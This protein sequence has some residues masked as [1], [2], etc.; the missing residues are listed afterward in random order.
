MKRLG[1]VLLVLMG[2][3]GR[4]AVNLP[5]GAETATLSLESR[6]NGFKLT[7][8]AGLLKLVNRA[9]DRT[10]YTDAAELIFTPSGQVAA[11]ADNSLTLDPLLVVS[12]PQK[13]TLRVCADGTVT[14]RDESGKQ[15]QLGKILLT[16]FPHPEALKTVAN[17]FREATAEAG[18]PQ[19]FS[20]QIAGGC[21]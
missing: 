10:V 3:S 1:W 7:A 5:A 13:S 2:C 14:I 18:E 19:T 11:S 4:P 8:T 15:S 21:L 6:S 9:D 12:A 20:P 16:W 17:G